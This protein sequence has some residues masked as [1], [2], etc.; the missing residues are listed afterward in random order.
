MNILIVMTSIVKV[1]INPEIIY[2]LSYGIFAILATFFHPFFF[3]FHLTEFLMR[4]PTL[5]GIL[6]SIYGPR[7]ILFMV[8]VL[9]ALFIYVF[10][11][12]GYMALQ[13]DYNGRCTNLFLCFFDSFDKNFKYHGGIGGWL[14][15]GDFPNICKQTAN[16]TIKI[17]KKL[18]FLFDRSLWLCSIFLRQPFL[19]LDH[20]SLGE[21]VFSNY[22]R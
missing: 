15:I 21:V 5:R 17:M 13:G 3:A 22:N 19:L 7:K 10:T 1:L 14:Q 4:Y 2:Y 11:V 8:F 16:C 12:V 18:L 6:R 9:I 20:G